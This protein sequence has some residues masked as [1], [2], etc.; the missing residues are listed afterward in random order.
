MAAVCEL[1]SEDFAA[2]DEFVLRHPH[3]SPFHLTAW[4][5]TIEEAFGY[6]PF[7]LSAKSG[8]R[9]EAVLPLFFVRNPIIGSA[10]ISSPFA[11]YGG[12]L[13]ESP[14]AGQLLYDYAK[15]L[16][17]KVSA[18][19]IELRNAYG[20]QCVGTPNV[21][22]YVTFVQDVAA[23]EEDLLSSLPKKTRNTVRKALK[24]PFTIRYRVA[25]AGTLDRIHS[26]NMRRLGTP[27]FP[28]EYF[29]R[30]QANFGKMVEVREVRL[31]D[32]PVAVS[33]SFLFRDQMHTY[34]AAADTRYNALAP[35][36]FL[37]YDHLR[38]AGQHGFRQFD[39]G[40]SKRNTGA[41]E[42]KRH[43]NTTMREL[44]Y[45]IVL[46]KRRELPNFSPANP[47]FRAAIRIWQNLPLPVTRGLSK[48][49]LP[50]FP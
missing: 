32:E 26:R 35:N 16:G 42:F 12:I 21:S 49:V 24:Q 1:K 33:L 9:V 30:L 40:R 31:G 45:E 17:R 38:W 3:G 27:C 19:Y 2:W 41:F 22:R 48:F 4:K 47:R 13:A 29:A 43:W 11:V 23:S 10:L 39:F 34:H 25:D 6:Q 36:T 37:Y 5:K 50:L 18:D 8:S 15:W 20:E 14:Q 46:L 7:Y 44:P 28:R